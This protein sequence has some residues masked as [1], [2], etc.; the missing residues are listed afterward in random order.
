MYVCCL[1]VKVSLS[2]VV[3]SLIWPVPTL[4]ARPS[5]QELEAARPDNGQK[6]QKGR[7]TREYWY[8]FLAAATETYTTDQ[9]RAVYGMASST[10]RQEI[11]RA[12]RIVARLEEIEQVEQAGGTIPQTYQPAPLLQGSRSIQT[13]LRH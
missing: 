13:S 4:A 10:V 7:E 5:L 12:R 11:T 8:K 1:T 3:R 9:I 6:V 2:V